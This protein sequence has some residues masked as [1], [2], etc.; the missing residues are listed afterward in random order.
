[1]AMAFAHA[2]S[3]ANKEEGSTALNPYLQRNSP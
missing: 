2:T 3:S 1:M